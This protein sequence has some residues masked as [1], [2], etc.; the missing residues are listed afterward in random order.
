MNK[1]LMRNIF[2]DN[3]MNKLLMRNIFID[4]LMI[5][6]FKFKVKNISINFI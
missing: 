6:L 2:I 3:L 1:L 4:N 5:N